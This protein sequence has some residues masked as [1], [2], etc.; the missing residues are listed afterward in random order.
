MTDRHP[1]QA[2]E[3]QAGAPQASEPQAG[4]LH[5]ELARTRHAAAE[6][7]VEC[8]D[9]LQRIVYLLDNELCATEIAEVRIHLDG[10]NPCQE[11]YDLQRRIKQLVARSCHETAPDGLR[12]RITVTLRE[13]N[14]RFD[15]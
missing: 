10:C 9:F 2:G 14:V 3:T 11:T 8:V 6:S 1:S 12:E 5:E 7:A 15:R 4:G 13:L